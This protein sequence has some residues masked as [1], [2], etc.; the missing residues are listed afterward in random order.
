MID[1]Q[2]FI[3]FHC[4]L[5]SP[6]SYCYFNKPLSLLFFTSICTLFLFS[7]I[8]F[9]NCFC[10]FLNCLCLSLYQCKIYFDV[11]NSS[12]LFQQFSDAF[13]H[14]FLTSPYS[15]ASWR[16]PACWPGS[17]VVFSL[18]PFSACSEIHPTC[19]SLCINV[20]FGFV[21]NTRIMLINF[22][23]ANHI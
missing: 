17:A 2:N 6:I 16:A 13:L 14:S 15:S 19:I 9:P 12:I 22:L 21:L 5:L 20:Q 23:T 11:S 10:H 7:C 1:H 3:S 4:Q 8:C 18:F